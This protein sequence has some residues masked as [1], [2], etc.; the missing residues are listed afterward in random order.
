MNRK[1]TIARVAAGFL[2]VVT[3]LSSA[4]GPIP[5]MAADSDADSGYMEDY[6]ELKDVREMLDED[7]IVEADD[8]TVD[9]DEDFEIEKDFKGIDYS[10]KKVKIALYDDD[11]FS[12]AKE[13]NYKPVY[14]A[15]P[16]SGNH[17][18]RFSR[19]ITVVKKE[20]KKEASPSGAANGAGSGSGSHE[21]NSPEKEEGT[22]DSE[23]GNEPKELDGRIESAEEAPSNEVRESDDPEM[24]DPEKE[25]LHANEG[26][27]STEEE[28]AVLQEEG[29]TGEEA[30][31]SAEMKEEEGDQENGSLPV[32]LA[33]NAG[34]GNTV[35]ADADQADIS[36]EAEEKR[37]TDLDVPENIAEGNIAASETVSDTEEDN[38]PS[39]ETD[40]ANKSSSEMEVAAETDASAEPSKDET[41]SE[42]TADAVAEDA[43]MA[44]AAE[45]P[46]EE[47]GQ[48]VQEI[49]MTV[50]EFETAFEKVTAPS[51]AASASNNNAS[52]AK[53]VSK[54]D[55]I[56][57]EDLGIGEDVSGHIGH[58]TPVTVVDD[59]GN[60]YVGICAV[61]DDRGWNKGSELPGVSRV[62][63]ALI[64]KYYYYTMLDSYGEDLAMSRGFGS[65]SKQVAIAVCH[66]AIGERYSMLAGIEYER[67]NVGSN[68]RALINAYKSG[69]AAKPLPDMDH[70]FIYASGRIK[71]DGHWRQSYVFGRVEEEEPSNIVLQKVSSDSDM[72]WAYSAYYNLHETA[73]GGT[74]N[75]R[76]YSDRACTQR[77]KVYVDAEKT[78]ELDPIPIGRNG[79]SG[80]YNKTVFY[81]EPGTVYLKEL[82]TPKGYEPHDEPFGPYTLDEGKGKT[83]KIKNTPQ[84]AHVGIVKKDSVDGKGL[85]GARFSLYSDIEDARNEEEPIGRFTTGSDGRSNTLEVLAGKQYYIRET[86]APDGYK[87]DT[88]VRR[89][90]TA[91]SLTATKWTNVTD[92]P[93]EP[94]NGK[95][96]LVKSSADTSVTDGNSNYSLAGAVYTVTDSAGKSVGTL[97]TKA[98]GSSNTLTLPLG[99]Y[100]VKETSASKGFKLDTAGHT[101]KI[102]ADKTETVKSLEEPETGK[103]TLVKSSA[104]TSVSDGN[105]NY[106]L[107]GAVYTVTD[108][109][110]KSVGT[111]TTK[112][113]GS[114]NTL[115]LPLGTYT[116]KE[117]SASK[118]FKLDTAGHTVRITADKTETVKSLEE[119]ETGKVTLVKSSADTSVTD[120]NS[121]YSLA[122]AVYTVTDNAGKSVGKLTTKEDGTSN[123]LTLPLGTYTVK[124]TNAS[125]GFKLD[126]AGHTVKI[127][128]DKTET[129]KSLE[130]PETGK[131]TLVKS[132][133][134]PEATGPLYSLA[135]AAYTVTDSAG[136]SVGKLTTKEDGTSNTLTLPLGTYTVKETSASSGFKLDTK[137]QT[138]TIK[139]DQT[140]TVKSLEEPIPGKITLL[141]VSSMEK[142]GKDPDTLPI[143]GAVYAL[144]KTK[145]DAESGKD[146][147]GNF[148][149]KA[150]GTSNVIEVLGGKTYYVKET[151]VPEGYLPDTTVYSANVNTLTETIQVHSTDNPIFGGVKIKKRDLE[152]GKDRSLGGATLEGAVFTIYNKSTYAV[153]ADRKKI[154]TGEATMTITT[155]QTG[156]AQ[157]GNR[158]LSYGDYQ[159]VET[160]PP[161]G[162]TIKG[163][164]PVSFTIR[165][166][167]VIVDL[168]EEK[169][170]IKNQ[171]MRGDFSIRK[172]D[173]DSQKRMAG[174]TFA[175]TALDRDGKEIEEHTFTTDKNGIFESTAAFAK[176]ENVDRIW[177][178]VDTKENDSLGAL[179]YGD[180]HIAEIEG[181]N[182]Q[183]MEMFEDDFSVYADM[184]TITLGNIENHQKPSIL[185]E[186]RGEGDE[187][188]IP[189]EDGV[190]LTDTVYME[191]FQGFVGQ[192]VT[193][194]G[195]LIDKQ[196]GTPIEV[197]G[198]AVEAETSKVLKSASTSVKQKFTFD[199]SKLAGKTVVCYEYVMLDD[200][201]LAS[202]T[203]LADEEQ[204]VH[205]PSVITR[206]ADKATRDQVGE[207]DGKVTVIDK[208]TYTN[209]QPG[210]GYT[211]EGTLMDKETG[212][213]VK[214]NS[215][216]DVYASIEF[217]ASASGDGEV[218][219]EF[220]FIAAPDYPGTDAVAFQTV[221]GTNGRT[222]ASREDLDDEA[223][224]IHV[225][226]IETNAE[227]GLTGGHT[228]TVSEETVVKDI[229]TY[230][231]L[232]PG[233][234]YT[235]SGV[236]M[237]KETG[238]S[239]KDAAGKEI[240]AEK[241]FTPSEKAGSVELS[242]TLDSALLEGKTV[243]TFEELYHNKILVAIHA[244]I[245][246]KDQ[247]IHYPEIRT[248]AHD[249]KTKDEVGTVLTETTII[250]TVTYKNLVPGDHYKVSGILMNKGTGKP[251]LGRDGKEIA[252]SAEFDAKEAE[253]SIEMVFTLD[254]DILSGELVE[255]AGV[256]FEDLCNNGVKVASHA[257]LE[258]ADQTVFYP[259]IT[260]DAKD[261]LTGD[262]S[263]AVNKETTLVDVVTYSNLVVGR[264]Y[265]VKGTLMNKADGKPLKDAAGKEVSASKTFKPEQKNGTVELTFRFDA[266]LLAGT[267]A[268]AFEELYH[269]DIQ[270]A[271]HTD[272][273]DED[274]SVHYPKVST[275]AYDE[276]TGSHLGTHT[277]EV[278]VIDIVHY[279]NLLTGKEYTVKGTLMDK[280]TGEALKDA[281]GKAVTAEA[282]FVAGD[283]LKIPEEPVVDFF[284]DEEEEE[285]V[286][287]DT[288]S[289]KTDDGARK[290]GTVTSGDVAL[291]FTFDSTLLMGKTVV[292]FEDLYHNDVKVVSHADIND[293][294]QS[295]YYPEVTTN[296]EDGLT[297]DHTGTIDEKVTIKDIVTYSNVIPG[298]EY[299]VSGTLMNKETGEVLYDQAGNG[300][301]AEE[302][303]TAEAAQGTVT[304]TFTLDSRLLEGTTVVAFEDMFQKDILVAVHKDINDED[305]SIHYPEIRTHA[306]DSMTSTNVGAKSTQAVV[307]DRVTYKNLV[308]GKKYTVSGILMDKSD[309]SEIAG[310]N[311]KSITAKAEFVPEKAN[312]S[313]ELSFK[314]DSTLL[315]GKTAVAFEDLYFNGT[316]VC[317][318][319]DLEDEDQTV[320]F[321]EIATHASFVTDK[322]KDAADAKSGSKKTTAKGEVKVID[323]VT[324]RNLV[325]GKEYT[326]S[327]KLMDQ[328]TGKAALVDKKELTAQARFTPD[329]ASGS[330]ELAFT[331]KADE[332]GGKNLVAFEELYYGKTLIASHTDIKD[333]A[334][335]VTL[336]KPA[337]SK[338]TGSGGGKTSGGK[339]S[340]SSPKTGDETNIFLFLIPMLL[341][342]AGISALAI[343]RIRKKG[344]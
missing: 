280:E 232:I 331:F 300:L 101:V 35:A 39:M 105:S 294:D 252:E 62:T 20:E 269:N 262:P 239:L 21:G 27:G 49:A 272:I 292:A 152:T 41:A 90:E 317:S 17:G 166:D 59:D 96:T 194:H 130:K 184:Q 191:D 92:E 293:E 144:Y 244:D 66:E 342:A 147:I 333:E 308:P 310:K 341:A 168:T 285:A 321:P 153:Y 1:K 77:V 271:V 312:G 73:S 28:A 128:A 273:E 329:K 281:S 258:D 44:D 323:K 43:T 196:T 264:T 299:T 234:E 245:E 311:G 114:S 132:S 151:K 227:D 110:G 149:V 319:A 145:E 334:Q 250:D 6:P 72:R 189:A 78:K 276:N 89:L 320:F 140:E 247:S 137:D 193:V 263:G 115:T 251:V 86:K 142:D 156:L 155:D 254:A 127:T 213:A 304:L 237:N 55:E 225:P 136:K 103:V 61:P 45:V 197:G 204:T 198:K 270:V 305:Q 3:F 112:A 124:E 186:L 36:N 126:T 249:G 79:V 199:A 330:I 9:A 174:V 85:P 67:P 180:Y 173:G 283:S 172:I 175:V 40:A 15:D 157:T 159:I 31:T 75:F 223:E 343:Y 14:H 315:A 93:D 109:A 279:E 94:E 344:H 215:G 65:K 97:T 8:I 325:P 117:T 171:V 203:D 228:G 339:A 176:K 64:I 306:A 209:L 104:D 160:T 25:L 335:T 22:D 10:S 298:K 241:A 121:N 60:T 7:E 289:E 5:A 24:D 275:N 26:N 287:A 70:V 169:D 226:S 187:Q 217:V 230:H 63:D 233:K 206:A 13:G 291:V 260:T 188:Y 282:V 50:E 295:I 267:T 71:V 218:E 107:A 236:L 259:A 340:V 179:P 30:S 134:D 288:G 106:S 82:T 307:V 76:M 42:R 53:I 146:A 178:G 318:H 211:M 207:S 303:F 98:D 183:G 240:S 165:E 301:V 261:G 150:D 102:T 246:D 116:V 108:S 133:A 182:N 125:K 143:A 120:V 278:R 219:I 192:K 257:D 162:Y 313:V 220:S 34:E 87:L 100:T 167:G 161:E 52:G 336:E 2:S 214:D 200:M 37:E 56:D 148:T 38:Y 48:S 154:P 235:V 88:A 286:P 242:F 185:T 332:L 111:L 119:P 253:G 284:P 324:Y 18:Y 256:V 238:E 51:L 277:E 222:Y 118:G 210:K 316:R 224:T 326:I 11:G 190:V 265:M 328:K 314:V 221:T 12:P 135:G 255:N 158:T 58:T 338:K 19:R 231:N 54:E 243:V 141:K 57:Y 229:V 337:D 274:Q 202:H 123:T 302:T 95:V 195:V 80:L 99:T 205:F 164:G 268:V 296:A 129:V 113:D 201:T 208:V 83:I 327:G 33:D 322:A 177:F 46:A 74:V 138:V 290:D 29:S 47:S 23:E 68:L 122:G 181:E 170:S 216:D 139:A 69:V 163:A 212:K 81:C 32:E 297:K 131:V 266:S 248:N 84:Y 91:D 309:G 4:I 16:R